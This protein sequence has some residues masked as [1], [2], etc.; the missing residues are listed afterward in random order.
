[1]KQGLYSSLPLHPRS[2]L[3]LLL[4]MASEKI[5]IVSNQKTTKSASSRQDEPLVQEYLGWISLGH[6]L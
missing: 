2:L 4:L 5:E 3:L 6:H 1:M